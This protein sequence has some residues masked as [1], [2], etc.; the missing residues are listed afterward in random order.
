MLVDASIGDVLDRRTTLQTETGDESTAAAEALTQRSVMTRANA[1][2]PA[3]L[4]DGQLMVEIE[5]ES[6][7]ALEQLYDRYSAR[8]YRLALSIC[9]D[10]GHAEDA[11]QNA[12]VSIWKNPG[13]YQEQ[14]GTV[15]TW[16]LTIVRHRTIDIVRRNSARV[17]RAAPE[18]RLETF[19]VPGDARDQLGALEQAERMNALLDRLP[20]AQHE[21][22][23]L[24]FYGGLTH[25]EIAEQLGL[26]AGTVKGQMRL[27]L[28]KLRAAMQ[29]ENAARTR[30][31]E[32]LPPSQHTRR[33]HSRDTR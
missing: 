3:L 5:A 24:A 18:D 4:S 7:D 2:E 17:A 10:G 8:A 12:F 9:R 27:G 23:T 21:V 11:V 31:A 19:G 16:L 30:R 1:P 14:R 29:R 32:P 26:P 33:H 20:D 13:T 28:H 22:I 6:V 15:S 25:T